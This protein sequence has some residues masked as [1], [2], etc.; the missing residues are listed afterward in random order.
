MKI[1]FIAADRMEFPG[2]LARAEHPRPAALSVDWAHSA[3]FSNYDMLLVANGVGCARSAA[4]VDI[5]LDTF[6]A[7]AV[8]STGFCGALVPDLQIADIVIGT[9]VSGES[10]RYPAIPLG[11]AGRRGPVCSQSRIAQTA[12]E[13]RALAGS[14]AIAVEM[15]AAGVASRTQAR[16]LPFHCV[17]AVTDLAEEDMANDFNRALR[18][19]GHFDTIDLLK[20]SLRHPSERIPEL[21]RLRKRCGRAARAL[22]DFFADC[23]F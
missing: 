7:D 12:A 19:D 23:R 6:P 16:G 11:D 1:L 2:L 4:A 10:T 21:I 22:G 9:C 5:A 15:E 13:K 3:H 20:N 8:I 14:G 18:P 17:K